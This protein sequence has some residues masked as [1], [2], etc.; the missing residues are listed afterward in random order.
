MI[1]GPGATLG[2]LPLVSETDVDWIADCIAAVRRDG[3]TEIEA[4]PE[5]QEEWSEHVD[6]G[7]GGSIIPRAD[8]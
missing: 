6:S 1:T 8:S 5:A 7:A 2:N 4:T 3:H